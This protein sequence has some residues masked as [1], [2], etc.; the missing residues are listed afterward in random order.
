MKAS[1]LVQILNNAISNYGDI[2]VVLSWEEGVITEGFDPKFLDHI[3]DI[4]VMPDWPLPGTSLL[5]EVQK[6][7]APEHV[8]VLLY[9]DDSSK[10]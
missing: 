10:E 9:G 1:K 2:N 5:D 8:I 6:A 7:E 4:R 3:N